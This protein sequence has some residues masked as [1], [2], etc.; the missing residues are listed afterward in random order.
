MLRFKAPAAL[1]SLVAARAMCQ[2]TPVCYIHVGICLIQ[3]LLEA[4]NFVLQSL[5]PRLPIRNLQPCPSSLV[6][7]VVDHRSRLVQPAL[8]LSY[9]AMSAIKF[10]EKF[11]AFPDCI[12]AV[13]TEADGVLL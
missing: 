4:F 5:K 13:K 8:K 7:K 9:C 12:F 10:V 2:Q 1:S 3:A 11:K 6:S